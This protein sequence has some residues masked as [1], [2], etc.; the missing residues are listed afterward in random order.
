MSVVPQL[1]LTP[2]EFLSGERIAEAKSEYLN[3]EVYAMAGASEPH[4][5]IVGN[6]IREFGNRLKGR[7][8]R[9]YPSDMRLQVSETGLFTYPDVMVVCDTPVFNDDKVDTL[10]NPNIIIEV[11]SPTTEANDRGW[12]WAHYRQLESLVEYILIPQEAYRI[13]QFVRQQDGAW[14]FR[15][16]QGLS[17]ALT[18]YSPNCEIALADIYYLVELGQTRQ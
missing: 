16:Y 10:L 9:I 5:L 13:E 14:V 8:C 15:E 6:V 1:K 18:V 4:N 12:K 2:E 3:G 17:E 11:L 7:R